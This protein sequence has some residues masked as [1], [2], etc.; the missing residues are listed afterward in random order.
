MLY[1]TRGQASGQQV[2]WS[3]KNQFF[4]KKSFFKKK[5]KE[6][7]PLHPPSKERAAMSGLVSV[8]I[9]LKEGG[10]VDQLSLSSSDAVAERFP[11]APD[12]HAAVA[13]ARPGSLAPVLD[14]LATAKFAANAALTEALKDASAETKGK[15]KDGDE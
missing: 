13:G 1:V 6:F 2:H 12:G 9:T 3:N 10:P 15:D 8:K 7:F 11:G 5:K 14:A 4:R